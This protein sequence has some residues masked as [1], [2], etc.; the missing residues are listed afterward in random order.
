MLPL[1]LMMTRTRMRMKMMERRKKIDYTFLHLMTIVT[2]L[3]TH[4]HK[5]CMLLYG[6]EACPLNA[7]DIRSLHLVISSVRFVKETVGG[8]GAEGVRCGLGRGLCSF[9]RKFL[10]FFFI[11][12]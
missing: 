5:V 1:M 7:S 9:A 2:L 3:S 12:K 8:R 4:T 6:L 11:S 10:I